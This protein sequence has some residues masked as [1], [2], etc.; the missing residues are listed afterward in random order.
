MTY[1]SL[2]L[3]FPIPIYCW[4]FSLLFRSFVLFPYY[5]ECHKN[6]ASICPLSINHSFPIK[7]LSLS[8]EIDVH[9]WRPAFIPQTVVFLASLLLFASSLPSSTLRSWD[10][11]FSCAHFLGFFSLVFVILS[12]HSHPPIQHFDSDF[13]SFFHL[14]LALFIIPVIPLLPFF[15]SNHLT[16][17][18]CYHFPIILPISCTCFLMLVILLLIIFSNP[19]SYHFFIYPHNFCIL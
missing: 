12:I 19:A 8:L 14:Y 7:L 15:I 6:N 4:W 10:L 17:N 5:K 18:H 9:G 3:L 1:Y 16:S 13:I 11:F 2:F